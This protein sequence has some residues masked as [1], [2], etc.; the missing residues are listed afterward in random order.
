LARAACAGGHPMGKSS[1]DRRPIQGCG[2][3]VTLQP[4]PPA[5]GEGTP[6]VSL[7]AAPGRPIRGARLEVRGDMAHG[8][9]EPV[10]GQAGSGD[11]QGHYQEA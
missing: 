3:R 6:T 9:M 7:S 10:L 11:S 2:V 1:G 8:A 4:D 5:P